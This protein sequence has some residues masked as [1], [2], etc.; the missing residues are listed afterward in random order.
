MA[1]LT[2][3]IEQE[4]ECPKEIVIWNYFD[5][6]H[7]VGTHYKHYETVQVIAESGTWCLLGH[8]LKLPFIG[9]QLNKRS[10]GILDTPNS[11]KCFHFG[12]MGLMLEQAYEFKDLGSERCLVILESRMEVPALFKIFQLYFEKLLYRWFYDTWDEDHPMRLRRWKVWKLGFKNFAGVDYINQ[13]TKKPSD[14]P[15]AARP[16]P[17]ELPVP[18]STRIKDGYHR[19]FKESVEVGYGMPSLP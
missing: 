11:M 19:L 12:P 14:R 17:I 16:Y 13:K 8:R 7:I 2:S 18:K 10:F 15:S 1:Y 6:E 9:F 5:H 4:M 3:R